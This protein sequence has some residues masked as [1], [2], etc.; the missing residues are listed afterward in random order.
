MSRSKCSCGRVKSRFAGRCRECEAF[1]QQRLYDEAMAVVSKGKCPVCGRKLR[2][3]S[4]ILGWYQCEQF[5]APGFRADPAGPECNYQVMVPQIA[6]TT[7]RPP[8][9]L[10]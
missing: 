6:R 4:A 8:S 9:S 7:A 5:G 2:H 3:N 1:H 10:V